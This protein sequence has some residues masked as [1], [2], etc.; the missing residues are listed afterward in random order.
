MTGAG[1]P[2]AAGI[3]KCLLQYPSIQL[4]VGDASPDATGRYI[5]K[6][7]VQLPNGDDPLFAGGL[8]QICK[9][10]KI[11]LVMPLVSKELLPLSRNKKNFQDAGIRV[12]VSS[13]ESIEIAD[14]KSTS[15]SFLKEKGINVPRFFIVHTTEEFIHAAFELGHPAS[16]VCFKPSVSNGSRGFRIVTDSLDEADQLFNHKPYNVHITYAH[17][18]NILSSKNFPQLLVTEYLP[19][20]EYSVD[21]ICDHGK[22]VLVVPRVREKMINGISVK[23]VFEKNEKVIEYC[24]KIINAIGLHGNIGIQVK[25]SDGGEPLLVEI[26]PRV[27]GT[28]VAGLGAG[29]N[30]PLLALRQELG[31]T[32]DNKEMQVAWGTRFSRHWTEIFY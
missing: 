1:A 18:L 10:R 11:Q 8:L 24:K 6:D 16:P 14:N 19:G 3:I 20:K 32:L 31:Q 30:L 21:C 13:P 26:N 17:A 27:Q 12:M 7:F 15:Y 5:N 4:T 29:V 22:P 9:E 28:I 25:Y 2:G 23:G